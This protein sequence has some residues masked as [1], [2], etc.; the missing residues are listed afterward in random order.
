MCSFLSVFDCTLEKVVSR[1]E[2]EQ[3]PTPSFGLSKNLSS[4][5]GRKM[6]KFQAEKTPFVAHLG[7][8]LE[9]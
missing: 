6:Q 7:A 4:E 9:F 3:L 8:E 5:N 2:G 1:W